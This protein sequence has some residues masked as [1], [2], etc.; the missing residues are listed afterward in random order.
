MDG[1]DPES[2]E[3]RDAIRVAGFLAREIAAAVHNLQTTAGASGP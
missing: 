3:F 2:G 1:M